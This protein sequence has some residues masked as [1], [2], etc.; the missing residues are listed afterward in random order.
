[1]TM[2]SWPVLLLCSW[3]A[4]CALSF[5]IVEIVIHSLNSDL[6]GGQ[7]LQVSEFSISIHATMYFNVS[8]T[9]SLVPCYA[10]VLC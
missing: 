5:L 1:M 7:Y 10:A 8:M 2:L 4:L 3:Q 6:S 9:R